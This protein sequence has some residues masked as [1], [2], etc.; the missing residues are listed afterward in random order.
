MDEVEDEGEVL[1]AG[2]DGVEGPVFD[3]LELR[4]D[5]GCSLFE[6]VAAAAAEEGEEAVVLMRAPPQHLPSCPPSF[7]D[8]G[9][10]Y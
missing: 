5:Q 6:A 10:P 9:F 3:P 7:A 8:W 1:L 4:V 2:D